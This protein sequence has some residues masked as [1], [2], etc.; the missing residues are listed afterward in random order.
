[1]RHEDRVVE[2]RRLHRLL[3]E[4]LEEHNPGKLPE[5]V[6]IGKLERAYESLKSYKFVLKK[7]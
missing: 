6:D 4:K 2:L 1:M 5:N 3:L 7:A